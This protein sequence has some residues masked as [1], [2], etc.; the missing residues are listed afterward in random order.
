M[1]LD[2]L[3]EEFSK[4]SADKVIQDLCRLIIEWKD[5][6]N[7]VEDL[8]ESIDKYLGNTWIE[9][10]EDHEKIYQMWSAFKEI[11]ISGIGGMTM[12]ERL[13]CFSLFERFDAC[14]DENAKLIIY[15][16]LHAN[17]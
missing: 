8:N 13:Y 2:E 10:N 9:R 1:N 15:R 5:N 14:A 17:P 6:N 3:V 11:A 12:N 4:I 7:T 16:K